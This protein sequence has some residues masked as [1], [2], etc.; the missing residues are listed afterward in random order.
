MLYVVS[1][2]TFQTRSVVFPTVILGGVGVGEWETLGI[3]F[4]NEDTTKHSRGLTTSK[5]HVPLK[6][7]QQ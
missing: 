6:K 7:I 5:L 1:F 3:V 2:R 4:C